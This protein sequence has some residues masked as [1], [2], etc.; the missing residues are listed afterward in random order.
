MR[1][2]VVETL[3]AL[4]QMAG[5]IRVTLPEPAL[6]RP[7]APTLKPPL[8]ASPARPAHIRTSP[9]EVVTLPLKSSAFALPEAGPVAAPLPTV[10]P[11]H[12][13]VPL[14]VLVPPA[15]KCPP[16]VVMAP[17]T[18][19]PPSKLAPLPDQ[20]TTFNLPELLEMSCITK[21]RRLARR[22]KLASPPAVLA[23][24]LLTVIS[25]ALGLRLAS[26]VATVTLVPVPNAAEMPAAAPAST[27]K[28]CGSIN[29]K[30]PAPLGDPASTTKPVA[31]M[32]APEVST[33]P[34]LP[35]LGPP[36]A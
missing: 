31:A 24:A 4:P 21:T 17:A 1:T 5:V 16:L 6:I 32:C 14:F 26:V 30:P 33:C 28:S 12:V 29:H 20:S 34:P 11:F 27:S 19:T 2:P 3:R 9:P 35:P 22:T 10:S 36:L 7:A 23:M 8:A 13:V 25:P 15:Q 18:L